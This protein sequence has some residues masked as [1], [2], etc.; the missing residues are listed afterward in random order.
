MTLASRPL[1]RC[2]L[3]RAVSE[4]YGGRIHLNGSGREPSDG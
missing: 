4:R 3:L 1:D 2:A